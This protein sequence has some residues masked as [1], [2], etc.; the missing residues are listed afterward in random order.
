MNFRTFFNKCIYIKQAEE[1]YIITTELLVYD[2][3]FF[4]ILT[5]T[6]TLDIFLYHH[7]FELR[8]INV[9]IL[10][11]RDILPLRKCIPPNPQL[12]TAHRQR[13]KY[14]IKEIFQT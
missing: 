11:S 6:K 13:F 3:I 10:V 2:N 9:V 5:S 7:V 4:V 14:S 8:F 12:Y 1:L